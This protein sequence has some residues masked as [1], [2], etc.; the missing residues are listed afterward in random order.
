[1]H[2][3]AVLPSNHSASYIDWPHFHQ[4]MLTLEI[5]AANYRSIISQQTETR[6]DHPSG[7]CFYQESLDCLL[8][9]RKHRKFDSPALQHVLE[10]SHRKRRSHVL[11]PT[12]QKFLEHRDCV[13]SEMYC[14][15]ELQ[16]SCDTA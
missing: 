6:N 8:Q 1:M 14:G 13:K 16:F 5:Q 10:V 2:S 11:E 4:L 3:T 15:N 12:N 9:F 7:V